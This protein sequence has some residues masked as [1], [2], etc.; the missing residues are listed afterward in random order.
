MYS[1]YKNAKITGNFGEKRSYYKPG[2][3]HQGIDIALGMNSPINSLLA[4]T[5]LSV[6]N[7]PNGY[8]NYVD[9][10]HGNGVVTR[11]G[12]ANS[13]KVKPGQKVKEGEQIGLVG[14]TGRS[15]GPHLHV[16]YLL[17]GIRKNPM[18][19]E[20]DMANMLKPKGTLGI[21][22]ANA[23]KDLQNQLAMQQI[24]QEQP[25]DPLRETVA[26]IIKT[27]LLN[28]VEVP[29]YTTLSD[30]LNAEK[31]KGLKTFADFLDNP[32]TMRTI[33]DFLPKY[34]YNPETGRMRNLMEDRARK[35]EA[36]MQAE[37]QKAIDEEK[38]QNALAS[39]MYGDFV[40]KDIADMND[41][42][43]REQ[44]QQNAEQFDKK[45]A[46]E[47]EQNAADRSFKQQQ[48]DA[49]I[50]HNKV[51]ED[52]ALG[53]STGGAAS[54]DGT[55]INNIK[56][57]AAERKQYTENKSTLANIDAGL[58]AFKKYPA[59]YGPAKGL[60]PAS[61]LNIT[62]PK[63]IEARAQIDNITAVYRKWLTG[64]QMSDKE[65]KAYE[66]FLPSPTDTREAIIRKLNS[67]KGAVQR[68]NDAILSNYGISSGGNTDPLGLG[69]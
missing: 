14:S 18:E 12:H 16:E 60:L 31:G 22:D 67:M 56:M 9:I 68:S 20:K 3:T 1:G 23:I 17:N 57:T 55:N 38:M 43:A 27:K 50:A 36:L 4:G 29:K 40:H 47:R 64:A 63:G 15:S 26:E 61:V 45:M 65:R 2:R 41:A 69:L 66:R 8:G 19:L 49:Q 52:I 58:K 46:F 28:P 25:T 13:F 42:R 62:D 44:I 33:G 39:N 5:V 7:D 32:E 35:K 30:V 59:A 48:L 34:G 6:K 37:Q 24:Q 21:Q 51:M 11:Y 54:V 53:K 10:D